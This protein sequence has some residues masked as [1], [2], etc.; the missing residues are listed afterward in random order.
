MTA[1]LHETFAAL[2]EPNRLAVVHILRE[3]PRRPA[4][5]AAELALSRPAISRHLRILRKSG[6]VEEQTLEDDARGRVY[7]LRREAFSELSEWLAEL[8]SFW[9]DQLQAFKAHAERQAS[10]KSRRS[11]K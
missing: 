2:G 6:L 1:Q 4:D 8:E 9:S 5:M 11:R 3:E 10:P 7:R